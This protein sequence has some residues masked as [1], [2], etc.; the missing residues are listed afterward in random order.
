MTDSWIH[1]KGANPDAVSPAGESTRSLPS[2]NST[3][4]LGSK[5]GQAMGGTAGSSR[6]RPKLMGDGWACLTSLPSSLV[7]GQARTSGG[8]TFHLS[9]APE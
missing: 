1:R 8:A 2:A 4:S 6:L 3:L 5:P 9:L 7:L